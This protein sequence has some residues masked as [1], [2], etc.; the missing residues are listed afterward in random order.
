[1]GVVLYVFANLRE[2]VSVSSAM[3]IA[4]FLLSNYNLDSDA[5]HILNNFDVI[6]CPIVNVDGYNH[7]WVVDR[8]WRKT[9]SINENSTCFGA[10]PNRK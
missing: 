7:S 5:T 10:D 6:I 8:L 9:R 3:Y 4:E 1:M 2:W